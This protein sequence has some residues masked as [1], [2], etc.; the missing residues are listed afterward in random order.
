MAV[1]YQKKIVTD[2]LVLCL[3]ASDIKSY[4]GTG[5]TWFDRSGNGKN[6]TLVNGPTY[7]NGAIVF[8]G[9]NDYIE[10][11]YT[12]GNISNQTVSCWIN[13]T[14]SQYSYILAKSASYYGFEIY[15]TVVYVNITDTQYGYV[16]YNINGWQNIV[17]TYDGTQIGNTNRLKI[18]INGNVQLLTFNGTIPSSVNVTDVIQIGRRWWSLAYSQGSISQV[19]IYNK[20]L[21]DSEVLQNYNAQK[22]RYGL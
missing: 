5:T 16:N 22:G 21:S 8:D 18:Y 3:D 4:S 2:G 10:T 9:S 13:K 17:F 20:A 7:S 15:P 1:N 12:S 14:N 11:A 6:G 19:A